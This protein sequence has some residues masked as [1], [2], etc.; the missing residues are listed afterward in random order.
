MNCKINKHVVLTILLVVSVGTTFASPYYHIIDTIDYRN[1]KLSVNWVKNIRFTYLSE[2]VY[3]KP[4][5]LSAIVTILRRQTED[6][7][8]NKPRHLILFNHYT[9]TGNM[10]A[11][12]RGSY[13]IPTMLATSTKEIVVSA[14]YPGFGID[15]LDQQG[16][17]YAKYNAQSSID[18][19][20]AARQLLEDHGYTLYKSFFNLGFS[21]GGQTAVQII[22]MLVDNPDLQIAK[23]YAGGGP[24]DIEAT[25]RW[26]I[27]QEQV[28]MPSVIPI[29]LMSF[30]QHDSLEI[31]PTEILNDWVIEMYDTLIASKRYSMH[32][33]NRMLGKQKI[34]D[35][36]TD[37][38]QDENSAIM[39]AYREAW[40]RTSLV[41]DWE[42]DSTT[43]LWLFHSIDDDVVPFINA[44]LLDV[45]LSKYKLP[46]YKT[47]F[48]HYG[49]HY[50][51]FFRYLLHVSF[52]IK[53]NKK[54]YRY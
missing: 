42:P 45:H 47:Q 52:D 1:N 26:Y 13:Y 37:S 39:L 10:E 38:V 40:Q 34:A 18:A 6:K 48:G 50:Q 4:D 36:I 25:Y 11:P 21:Q 20:R 17:Y 12:S 2:N 22:K 51:A 54:F 14:D 30:N 19:L 29:V 3:G 24:Y 44:E 28:S 32:S 33:V 35:V 27:A 43:N 7:E 8:K 53:N 5:T 15:S 46:K 41:D 49:N 23:S 9:I 16:Y 31:E